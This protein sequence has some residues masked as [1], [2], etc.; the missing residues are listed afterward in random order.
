MNGRTSGAS[1][2]SRAAQ[3]SATDMR[4]PQGPSASVSW[5]GMPCDPPSAA[6]PA[7]G[8]YKKR[9]SGAPSAGAPAAG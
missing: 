1:V 4:A 8:R 3:R 5:G 9:H 2:S 6:T 7:A